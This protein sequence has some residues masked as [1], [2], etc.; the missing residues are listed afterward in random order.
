VFFD[1]LICT[2]LVN[3]FICCCNE[4]RGAAEDELEDELE[5]EDEE[6]EVVAGV[7]VEAE[8]EFGRED[9]VPS[10]IVIPSSEFAHEV[11]VDVLEEGDD[12]FFLAE[13]DTLRV[14]SA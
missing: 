1:K 14:V 13:E 3:S 5:E 12:R 9:E 8:I 7:R 2:S 4:I 6:V 10:S 11:A